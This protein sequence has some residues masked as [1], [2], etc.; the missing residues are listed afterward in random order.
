MNNNTNGTERLYDAIGNELHVGDTVR[1]LDG[2]KARDYKA[3]WTGLMNGCVGKEYKILSFN[4]TGT[5]GTVRLEHNAF[6]FDTK[7]LIRTSTDYDSVI[8]ESVNAKLKKAKEYSSI[9]IT[10]HSDNSK[11]VECFLKEFTGTTVNVYYGRT[12]CC[13]EDTFNLNIGINIATERALDK[14]LKTKK[15]EIKEGT[16]CIVILR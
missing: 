4:K 1:I 13:P 8:T 9:D 7:Y 5:I 10:I 3:G 12:V 14:F 6:A 11:E 2:S 15:E 16:K